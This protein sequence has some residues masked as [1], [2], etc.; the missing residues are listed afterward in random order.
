MIYLY[1]SVVNCYGN[2]MMTAESIQRCVNELLNGEEIDR[3]SLGCMAALQGV[4][5]RDWGQNFSNMSTNRDFRI[6]TT[7]CTTLAHSIITP[8]SQ[9]FSQPTDIFSQ[10]RSCKVCFFHEK[11]IFVILFLVSLPSATHSEP[12][13]T[14]E[15]QNLI[16]ISKFG[17][18]SGDKKSVDIEEIEV[19]SESDNEEI[20]AVGAGAVKKDDVN[21]DEFEKI[22]P[23]K[24]KKLSEES[25]DE[26]DHEI[27]E[28]LQE[29]EPL[30]QEIKTD[31][32]P[33][34]AEPSPSPDDTI[35]NFEPVSLEVEQEEPSVVEEKPE[36]SVPTVAAVVEQ[37][38]S[39]P[40]Q[41]KTPPIDSNESKHIEASINDS[42]P[43]ATLIAAEPVPS[44]KRENSVDEKPPVPIQTYLW[45]DLK[46]A[47]EQVSGDQPPPDDV[48]TTSCSISSNKSLTHT[49]TPIN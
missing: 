7:A 13:T 2:D 33:H 27:E 47:K 34:K 37:K 44:E 1:L 29:A 22:V 39:E 28:I 14:L 31:I 8:L 5:T 6:L 17:S 18:G 43:K 49:Y 41:T 26:V 11:F 48:C 10:F 36:I 42:K 20:G 40:E 9:L 15:K 12:R 25:L 35:L 38:D 30:G 4:L 3:K 16:T 46:R 24:F 23:F 45:E 19:E 21:L 32:D